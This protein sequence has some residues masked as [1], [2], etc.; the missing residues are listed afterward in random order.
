MKPLNYVQQ[1]ID[2]PINNGTYQVEGT[3]NG[4]PYI[5]R[6]LNKKQINRWAESLRNFY[7]AKYG[8]KNYIVRVIRDSSR[9]IYRIVVLTAKPEGA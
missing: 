8:R 4:K 3:E 6:G 1:V 7:R 5:F 2:I 9:N